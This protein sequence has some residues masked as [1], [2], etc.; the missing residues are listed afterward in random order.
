MKFIPL[1]LNSG[2]SFLKSGIQF[3]KLAAFL[4]ENEYDVCGL[5]DLNVMYGFP[6]FNNVC[7]RNNIKEYCTY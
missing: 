1:H 2:Y 7:K 6:S 3:E 5:T 4:Q